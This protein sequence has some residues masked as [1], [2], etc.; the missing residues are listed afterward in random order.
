MAKKLLEAKDISKYYRLGALGSRSFKEDL[1]DWWTGRNT[2]FKET[3]SES[4][5]HIW[6]LQNVN[7][8]V[9]QGEVLG[10]I[11]KNGAGKST[12]L[13]IIS[14]ITLP[15]TGRICGNGR[16]A[17][18]LEVGTGFHGELTGRENIYL[19][20]HIMGMKKKEI[21][22]K[23]DEIIDF[24]GVSRF[25][26]TPVKRYSSGMYVRLAF[27]VAAHLDPE[28]LIIDEVL[29]V[30]DAE[31]Q[32]KCLDKIKSISREDGKTILF[33]SHN[34]QTLRNTCNRALVLDKGRIIASGDSE[35]VL[36]GYMHKSGEQFLGTDYTLQTV[37]PGNEMIRMRKVELIPGYLNDSRV[38]DVRTELRIEFE[39]EYDVEEPGQILALLQV[40]NDSGELIFELSSQNYH[41]RRGIVRGESLIPGNF[42]NDGLY[43]VSIAI[44]RNSVVRLFYLE[45]CLSFHVEDYKNSRDGYG[46]WAG[47]VRPAFPI[48][49]RQEPE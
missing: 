37:M 24:S 43:Y 14:R 7:F 9:T 45:S 20:G 4:P 22:R 17:S 36:A 46:K 31:F 44:V 3:E 28:I 25:L 30:G 49:L 34:I 1:R 40:Y 32:M 15:T 48:S 18:L 5:Q 11:G 42:L 16:I 38:I 12:L 27:A 6:A 47:V 35:S 29:A 33:V 41:L 21:E 2:R 8:E 39:F 10:L 26:D 23:F 19:N 13:K